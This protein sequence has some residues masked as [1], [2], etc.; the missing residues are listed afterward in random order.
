MKFYVDGEFCS[1]TSYRVLKVEYSSVG[2]DIF[3]SYGWMT[4]TLVYDKLIAG[5]ELIIE[6]D[7]GKQRKITDYVGTWKI[8]RPEGFSENFVIS[9]SSNGVVP[10]NVDY[11]GEPKNA[12][13]K[14]IS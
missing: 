10:M 8:D 13:H 6:D 1:I 7:N 5:T 3:C 12:C 2:V 4:D 11:I 9:L 14:N